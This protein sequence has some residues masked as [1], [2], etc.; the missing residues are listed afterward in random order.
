MMEKR[1]MSFSAAFFSPIRAAL[2][3]VVIFQRISGSFRE[4]LDSR[5]LESII[6]SDT[7]ATLTAHVLTDYAKNNVTVCNDGSPGVYYFA[8]AIDEDFKSVWLIYLPGGGQCFDKAS[9]AD[10]W[11]KKRNHMTSTSSPS[12]ILRTGLL[13]ASPSK[14]VLWGANKA[15]LLYCSSDGYMGDATASNYTWGWHFKGQRLVAAMVNELILKHGLDSSATIIF[16]GGSAV[17]DLVIV[18]IHL[19][20]SHCTVCACDAT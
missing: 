5:S 16:A 13:D 6:S 9:C 11:A 8:P 12:T 14:S 10:R 1:T 7:A 18:I 2:L 4:E 15:A 17:G 20:A 3:F 19:F